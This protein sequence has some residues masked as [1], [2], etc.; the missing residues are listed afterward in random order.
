LEELTRYDDRR[1]I[2][3]PHCQQQGREGRRE[4]RGEQRGEE[5]GE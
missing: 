2:R 5:R 1:L 4:Q 3:Y